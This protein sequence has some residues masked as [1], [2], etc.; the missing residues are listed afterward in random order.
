MP[1]WGSTTF[2]HGSAMAASASS[3]SP[4][5]S[6]VLEEPNELNISAKDVEAV[7]AENDKVADAAAASLMA[8]S[9]TAAA[10]TA[11]AYSS[12]ASGCS[13]RSSRSQGPTLR[14]H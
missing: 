5:E 8:L 12:A 14:C 10:L 13:F 1:A 7:K 4:D 3:G 6:D 2:A 11:S 9:A